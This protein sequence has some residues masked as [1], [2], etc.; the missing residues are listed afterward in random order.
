MRD[1]QQTAVL[2]RFLDRLR[3]LLGAVEAAAALL[4]LLAVGAIALALNTL[5]LE[6]LPAWP[7]AAFA[8]AVAGTL[9]IAVAAL[10]FAI[11]LA[12]P[13]RLAAALR[14]QA[15]E[16]ALR[17]DVESSLDLAPLLQAPAAGVSSKLVAALVA[18]TGARLAAVAP[19]RFVSWRALRSGALLAA[20]ALVP[21]AALAVTGGIPATALRALI[22]PR[23]SWP[24]GRLQLVVEP[25]DVRIARGADLLVRIRA[26]GAR[27]AGVAVEY[28]GAPGE[29][30]AATAR[31][32]QGLWSWRFVAV[33]GDF[34]YRAVAGGEATAWYRARV[35]DAPVAGNFE[36]RCTYPAYSRLPSRS[37]SGTGEVE[38]LKGT[39]VEIGFSTSVDVAKAS[40]VF[41][42]NR[43]PVRPTGERSHAAV[44]YLNGESS[45]R[46]ELED[47]GGITNGAGQEYAVRYLPDAPPT[48]EITD[49]EGEVE[50]DPRGT[51]AIRYRAADDY[52]LS[53]LSLVSRSA[54]GER[55]SPLPL[56]SGAR[57]A[58]DEYVW[59]LAPIGAQPGEVVA[60][61]VEAADNDTISGPKT[62]ASAP[63]LV[64]IADPRQRREEAREEL[65]RLA[66][67]L[68]Q[69]LGEELDVQARYQKL[70]EQ[71][72]GDEEFPWDE[73]AEAA[74]LQRSA[75][76]SAA[77]AEQRADRL[78]GAMERDPGARE[79]SIFQAD[80]IRQGLAEMRER[81]LA[82]MEEVAAGLD[83]AGTSREESREKTGFLAAT[84][85]QA[86][87]KAE[88]LA[89]MADALQREH[90]M[91]E[92]GREA[93]EMAG[94][95]D[96]LLAGL[97]RLSPGDRAAAE[98]VLKELGQI[99]QALRDLAE[100]LQKQSEEL[101]EEFLNS[102]A[103]RELDLQEVLDQLDQ[104]R[105]LLKQGDIAGARR[106]ARELAKQLADLRSRLQRAEDEVDERSRQALGRLQGSTVPRLQGLAERQRA[107]LERTEALDRQVGPRLD[108]AL[109]E[110]AR[111]G[112]AARP[113]GEADLLTPEERGRVEA[114]AREQEG[115]REE[116][117]SLANEVSAIRAA[118]PFFPAEVGASL[119]EAGGLMGEAGRLLGGR[120]PGRALLPE[121][122]ALA[123]LQRAA[124][125]AQQSLDELSEMQQM[126]Q[127]M[128]G[129]GAGRG[130][131]MGSPSFTR[132][133]GSS[134]DPSRSRRSGGRRGTDVR[135]FLLPGRQEHRVPKVF[136]E[137]IM[138]SLQEG[139]PARYEE[140]IKDYYQRITE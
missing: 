34:T 15:A 29:G 27:P 92:V 25:G 93:Q 52:G 106:A 121:R 44:L 112:G 63:I 40:L 136:R 114:L 99:E 117:R 129:P 123:A 77:R 88:Q 23:V 95:E 49:P 70:E 50:G 60:A 41:G 39:S 109:R 43:V 122:G 96:R 82:P 42:A 91:A 138:K 107:L 131:G 48:V 66:D 16:P 71:A 22:D 28:S 14:V 6:R 8:L 20:V 53:R 32:T 47:A 86:A 31:D 130:M 2:G 33:S 62:A 12:R 45:Y 73:A 126:R 4:R 18:T 54:S 83:V 97:E 133:G 68:L 11:A 78:A 61:F 69:L 127:G 87:R 13:S 38:A 110:L 84:A 137:E 118:L 3:L 79:E 64:R 105:Q 26:E 75:R 57:G 9:S 90:G 135:N 139:Y 5:F 85:E 59:D 120:E 76:E 94:A 24:L 103:L 51:L 132:P 125:R 58:G 74:A 115:L 55:R 89:L 35:V 124:D 98:E 19:W 67:D 111:S 101:P 56:T 113:P 72:R 104:V 10:R 30:S 134:G 140:R 108:A 7:W 65:E 81:L 116:A 80:L 46:I 37:F 1:R 21:L 17:N 100:A 102:E 119:E 36:I 128:P